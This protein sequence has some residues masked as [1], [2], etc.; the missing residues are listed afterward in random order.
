MTSVSSEVAT[1][2]ALYTCLYRRKLSEVAA[3]CDKPKK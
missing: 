2:A 3:S 1:K